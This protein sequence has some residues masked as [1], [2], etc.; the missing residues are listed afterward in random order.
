MWSGQARW[1]NAGIA[2]C[3]GVWRDQARIGWAGEVG[4]I[5]IRLGYFGEAGLVLCD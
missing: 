5:A 3:D 1:G 2:R 4:C